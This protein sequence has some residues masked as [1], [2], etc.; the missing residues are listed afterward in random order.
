MLPLKPINTANRDEI[1]E[2]GIADS[3]IHHLSSMKGFVVRPLSATRKYADIKQDPLAAGREQQVD[4]VLASNYQLA[5]GKI[6]VTAQ[7]FNVASGQIEETKIIDKDAVNVFATQDAIAGEVG[8]LLQTHFVTTPGTPAAKRGTTNEEAYRLYLHGK[9]LTDRRSVKDARKAVEYFEQAIRLDPNYAPAFAGMAHAYVALA[10]LGGGSPGEEYEKAR[11][12]VNKAL[13]L[14]NNLA[15]AYATRSEI[16]Y[17]YEWDFN[18]AEKDLERAQELDPN[19]DASDRPGWLAHS[20]RFDEAIAA[21]EKKL[22][23]DPNSIVLQYGRG[24]FLYLARRYDEAI[25]QLKRVLELDK[26]F[27]LTYGMLWQAYETKGDYAGAFQTFIDFKKRTKPEQVKVYQEAYEIGG[28]QGVR[29]K[30]LEFSKLD[31]NKPESNFFV[32]ARQY[33]WLGEKEQALVYLNKAVEKRNTQVLM[34]KVDP[35]FDI[36]RDDPRFAELVNRVG[37]K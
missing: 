35:A 10:I 11:A 25:A 27:G 30:L 9:N 20:G 22:E 4:Y 26:E 2:F 18:G 24:R 34:L 32:I 12:A 13:E 33:V 3:L 21:Q 16:K 5:D 15:E 1:Y 8:K 23:I 14:D 36:L 7:L 17:G 29:R 37:L 28:W 6:R 31:E 19:S